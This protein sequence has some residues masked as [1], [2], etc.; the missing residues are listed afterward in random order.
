MRFVKVVLLLLMFFFGLLFFVQN[1]T[2][3]S[4]NLKLQFDLYYGLKWESL[5]VPFYFVV[6]IAFAV[7]MLFA[8]CY[9]L[10]DRIRLSC[11][12]I[13]NKRTIRSLEKEVAQLRVDAAKDATPLSEKPVNSPR[14]LPPAE[15]PLP[16]PN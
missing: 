11:A 8:T 6:L 16:Q 4:T 15:E 9:L 3:L 12:N 14:K 5:E 2:A 13:G 1:G 10:I 7:G